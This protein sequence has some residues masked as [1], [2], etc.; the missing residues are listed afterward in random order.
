MFVRL[1]NFISSLIPTS[2]KNQLK[3]ISRDVIRDV[4]AE[5]EKT[6]RETEELKRSL[7]QAQK[8]FESG[9]E[10]MLRLRF[11]LELKE[12]Q[13]LQYNSRF[14]KRSE[15]FEH[16][17][18]K[19]EQQIAD[20]RERAHQSDYIVLT[21]TF[22]RLLEELKPDVGNFA[23]RVGDLRG[24]HRAIT[25]QYPPVTLFRR[26][27]DH[28]PEVSILIP[29]YSN[30]DLLLQLLYHLSGE[31]TFRNFEVIVCNDYPQEPLPAS[32]AKG[33]FAFPI[34]VLTNQWNSGFSAAINHAAAE[35]RGEYLLLLNSDILPKNADWLDAM[36]NILRKDTKVGIVGAKTLYTGTN[37]I[38]HFG[39]YPLAV[40]P[41][42]EWYNAHYFHR[43]QDGTFSELQFDQETEMVT[44][45]ALMVRSELFR[46]MKGLDESF[47]IGGYEDS[48]LC[49]KVR[50]AG[51]SVRVSA[52]AVL[53]HQKSLSLKKSTRF[54]ENLT[55]CN[56]VFYNSRW[57]EKIRE[58]EKQ[59]KLHPA[60]KRSDGR[61]RLL[62]V[63]HGH[64]PAE[65]GGTEVYNQTLAAAFANIEEFEPVVLAR[66]ALKDRP[67]FDGAICQDLEAK[68][69]LPVFRC[70]RTVQSFLNTHPPSEC[71]FEQFLISVRPDL[72]HFNH[73][74]NMSTNL[75]RVARKVSSAPIVYTLHEFLALCANNGLLLMSDGSLC[76]GP[77]TQKCALCVGHTTEEIE[78]RK[79]L[80]QENFSRVDLFISPSRQLKERFVQNGMEAT[81]IYYS[82]N[83]ISYPG[84]AR[85]EKDRQAHQSKIQFF[86]I[87][88]FAP[89]KGLFTLLDAAEK[90]AR[91]APQRFEVRLHGRVN[92]FAR[93]SE[94][95]QQ[96]ESLA[97]VVFLEGPYDNRKIYDL[98]KKAD[99]LIV[100]SIWYENSPLTIQE[101][102]VAGVPVI[103]S[104][105]GGMREL[106][107]D[108]VYGLQFQV[109][110][111][112]DLAKKMLSII[113]KPELLNT[114]RANILSMHIKTI[115]EN[116][117]ELAD[118]YRNLLNA[119]F[120]E[121]EPSVLGMV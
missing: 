29:V 93:Q 87:G 13:M 105:I 100:P 10:E 95:L 76:T 25:R 117:I 69:E 18:Q 84:N 90:L 55:A 106:V 75:V 70:Y 118:L 19:L 50:E 33:E 92:E 47:L 56:R 96:I 115:E 46:E 43:V 1:F 61:H 2:W 41:S 77:E 57:S 49:W 51:Y 21:N 71:E 17:R 73:T 36:V 83:G 22:F 8:A 11:A 42:L 27:P 74:E 113:E 23:D 108:G 54:T 37:L 62:F 44:G 103:T 3:Q 101:A 32:I 58:W 91:L 59:G 15:E 39:M 81:R 119:R 16:N 68:D 60:M 5:P 99:A 66:G 112:D 86:C 85:P 102:F 52:D 7:E 26:T 88:Q 82:Q 53:Y 6:T 97:G 9:Q 31:T 20:L 63:A 89:H 98:L 28:D 45:A 65:M 111:S 30:H 40:E 72:I 109:K 110:D 12:N 4:T 116:A 121:S 48:D 34:T 94:M 114:F 24:V 67:F 79:L 78:Q 80:Y 64:P 35:A 120:V 104:N 38:E 14:D 107:P